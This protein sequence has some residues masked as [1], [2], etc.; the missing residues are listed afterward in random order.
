MA[1]SRGIGEPIRSRL[2]CQPKTN[3]LLALTAGFYLHNSNPKAKAI[4]TLPAA[5][6][7]AVFTARHTQRGKDAGDGE[8]KVK[9]RSEASGA[10][11]NEW[12]PQ[13]GG[14]NRGHNHTLIRSKHFVATHRTV[15]HISA[16]ARGRSLTHTGAFS[17]KIIM[18]MVFNEHR[19][20]FASCLSSWQPLVQLFIALP[21]EH[22]LRNRRCFAAVS[23]RNKS[24]KQ[25]RG[26][27]T[28]ISLCTH[29]RT[30]THTHTLSPD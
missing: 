16:S 17:P 9:R 23:R 14:I 2:A 25:Q 26:N 27:I 18:Q 19:L 22:L 8:G 13:S 11:Q 5:T 4:C 28:F 12:T 24:W 15:R 3:C 30:H 29:A 7:G 6:C 21:G 10:P 20:S 1:E